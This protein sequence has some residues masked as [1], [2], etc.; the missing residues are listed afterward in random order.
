MVFE[1]YLLKTVSRSSVLVLFF[2][3]LWSLLTKDFRLFT[4]EGF[5]YGYL[6]GIVSRPSNICR[7]VWWKMS[8][9]VQ[10]LQAPEK[11]KRLKGPFQNPCSVLFSLQGNSESLSDWMS[12]L[13]RLMR[14]QVMK[15]SW[16]HHTSFIHSIAMT[17]TV[18]SHDPNRNA[19]YQP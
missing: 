8:R 16:L 12:P 7:E 5:R 14:V 11:S 19:E 18:E 13:K 17:G 15:G 10:T 3:F 6:C 2:F 4:R 9:P 1:V